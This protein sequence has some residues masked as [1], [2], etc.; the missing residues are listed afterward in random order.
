MPRRRQQLGP[1]T[2]V[3]ELRKDRVLRRLAQ[4]ARAPPRQRDRSPDRSLGGAG[5]GLELVLRRRG[6]VRRRDG[7]SRMSAA[8][9]VQ[10]R[11]P[12]LPLE[13]WEPTKD[14]LHLWAQI[15]GKVRMASTTPRNHWWH[16]PLYVDVRGLTTR[17]MHGT[18]GVTFEIDLDFVD[19]RLVVRRSG[20]EVESCPL[21][22]RLSVGK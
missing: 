15:V 1:S 9:D 6:C 10:P 7:R 21:R 18:G 13:E 16:V 4:S 5:R 14:T 11:L 12:A 20:G 3:H 17:R 8:I 19:H 2:H 22:E